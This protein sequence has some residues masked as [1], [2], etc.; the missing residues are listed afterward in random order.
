MRKMFPRTVI[1]TSS[2][3]GRARSTPCRIFIRSSFR[4]DAPP[5]IAARHKSGRERSVPHCL[6]PGLPEAG[7]VLRLRAGK[8]P[9]PLARACS[10]G[11]RARYRRSMAELRT[12]RFRIGTLPQLD[13]RSGGSCF[14]SASELAGAAVR[15]EGHARAQAPSLASAAFAGAQARPGRTRSRSRS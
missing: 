2:A 10:R 12:R 15:I 5:G 1:R 7:Q 9:G 8:R 3:P 13:C 6:D 14:P 11:P 4:E